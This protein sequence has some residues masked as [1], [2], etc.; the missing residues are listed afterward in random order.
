MDFGTVRTFFTRSEQTCCITVFHNYSNN[1]S[2]D[3]AVMTLTWLQA[4]R[5]WSCGL[6]VGGERG[7]SLCQNF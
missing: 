1:T 3:Y 5:L 4:G 7:L 6:I 2:Q